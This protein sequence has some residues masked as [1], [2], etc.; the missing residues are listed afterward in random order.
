MNSL[1]GKIVTL[2]MCLVVLSGQVALAQTPS[3]EPAK[4]EADIIIDYSLG[5][6]GAMMTM[7]QE[8]EVYM[9]LKE[10]ENQTIFHPN[11]SGGTLW[12]EHN[13]TGDVVLKLLNSSGMVLFEVKDMKVHQLSLDGYPPGDYSI[14]ISHK[15]GVITHSMLI[16]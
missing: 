10:E 12:L 13:L 6:K 16:K 5:S 14:V 7:E 11:P 8:I 1:Q 4:S 2:F 15:E 9:K 3:S